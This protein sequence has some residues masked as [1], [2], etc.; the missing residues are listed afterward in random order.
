MRTVLIGGSRA[1]VIE[2]DR[3]TGKGSIR[4]LK[5]TQFFPASKRLFED[6]KK[7]Q[8]EISVKKPLHNGKARGWIATAGASRGH[9]QPKERGPGR[10]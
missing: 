10:S 4:R 7:P 9:P 2:I 5:Y 6:N 8:K 3:L 1:R